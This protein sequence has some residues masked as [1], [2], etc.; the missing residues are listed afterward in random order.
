MDFYAI[1]GW[2]GAVSYILAYFLLVIKVL[3]A[4]QATYHAMNAFGGIC[5]VINALILSDMPNIVV[6]AVWG[7]LAFFALAKILRLRLAKS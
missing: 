6:N 5:L 3:S 1:I 2:V 7:G 4:E